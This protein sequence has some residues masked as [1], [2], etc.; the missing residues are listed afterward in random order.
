MRHHRHRFT[1]RLESLDER[2][3]P[4]V[5]YY[6]G[7]LLPHVEAQAVYLGNQWSSPTTSMPSPSTIDAS[8]K[9]LV[10]GAYMDSLSQ[11]GYN[12]GRGTA[13]TGAVDT[14]S[15]ASG[16]TISDTTIQSRI[17]A[18]IKSGLL[19]Q[20]DANRLY[21]VYVQPNV[22]VNLGFGQGTTQQGILGYHGAFGGTD[23]SGHAAT[24]R[25]AVVAY[26]G[27]TAH[28]SSL[29]VGAQDQLTAVASHEVSEAVTDP[30]ANYAQ[31]GW[32][33]PRYGEI[34]DITE[35][36][37]NA[38]V[39]LD[40]YLVQLAAGKNDQLL[41]LPSATGSTPTPTPSPSPTQSA[42]STTTTLVAGP[43]TYHW[44][45][46]ATVTLTAIISSNG[47]SVPA[48][49]TVE[50]IYN[51]RVLGTATV[52]L[53]NGTAIAQFS[54]AFYNYGLFNFTTHYVGNNATQPSV[55]NSLTVWV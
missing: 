33:D 5:L 35:S 11:A 42:I 12:V 55:S 6:G 15:L 54:I 1:P 2:C 51:G 40:G 44:F 16:S 48:G 4:T 14:T 39:R 34:G 37:P 23:S 49:G 29:G 18:D 8:L 26:P 7:N 25:Y 10:S 17:Q 3:Q 50:L 45:G 9:D 47:G 13:S 36:N 22:A 30:D 43:V 53:V 28:N 32:Y 31:L 27:G 38:L 52:R 46:P 20:P 41:S 24:I 19:Q 21:V